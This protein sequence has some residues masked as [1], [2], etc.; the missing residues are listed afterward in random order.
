[1]LV[2][3]SSTA[4]RRDCGGSFEA[5]GADRLDLP[6][7]QS[8]VGVESRADLPSPGLSPAQM[9]KS[10]ESFEQFK[11]II[12]SDSVAII[13]FWATCELADPLCTRSRFAEPGWR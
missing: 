1:M 12:N 7:V 2:S 6:T 11:E 3:R 9:V 10:I 5:G 8:L 4:M 13:D